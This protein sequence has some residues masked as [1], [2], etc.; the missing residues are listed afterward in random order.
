MVLKGS[1]GRDW[2]TPHPGEMHRLDPRVADRATQAKEFA[3]AHPAM[4]LLLKGS[5][6]V[7]AMHGE[8]LRFN[9][10]GTPAMAC[11]GMGDVLSG[12]CGALIAQGMSLYDAASMG[13][14]VLGRAAEIAVYS[15]ECSMESLAAT[16][17]ADHLGRAFDDS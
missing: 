1:K 2:L 4:T 16:D 13:S 6:T 5:R 7:I 12:L 11:G 10:T 8:P 14:W 9:T 17:V 3:K 15:G